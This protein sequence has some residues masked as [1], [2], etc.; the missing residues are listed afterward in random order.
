MGIL[1]KERFKSSKLQALARNLEKERWSNYSAVNRVVPFADELLSER[2]CR[3]FI[4]LAREPCHKEIRNLSFFC[5]FRRRRSTEFPVNQSVGSP[6]WNE[7]VYNYWHTK[8]IDSP[9]HDD[10]E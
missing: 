8:K 4:C 3:K 1:A 2:Q 9:E 10:W 7:K 5:N 6:H